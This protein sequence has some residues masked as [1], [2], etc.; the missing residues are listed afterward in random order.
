MTKSKI[1]KEPVTYSLVVK[2]INPKAEH[3]SEALGI[4]AKRKKELN[5]YSEKAFEKHTNI[6]SAFEEVTVQCKH[7]NEVAYCVGVM[8][9]NQIDNNNR[10]EALSRIGSLIS[11]LRGE[12][13]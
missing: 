4:T 3:I 5:D 1:K 11:K 7:I 13:K 9:S 2:E 8:V 6:V 10:S 12:D